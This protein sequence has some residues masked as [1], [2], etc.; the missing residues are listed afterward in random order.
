[1]SKLSLSKRF[2]LILAAVFLVGIIV[3]G[4]A[5]WRALQGRAQDE[6]S[7][8]GTLLI[9]SMNAV[10]SYTSTY[11]RPLLKDDLDA[12]REFIPETVPAFSARTVFENFRSQVD[13]E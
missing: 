7:V 2:T 8:Q 9:E 4:T 6:I 1:M 11:V 13:F 5:H 3:G 12:S 10:R